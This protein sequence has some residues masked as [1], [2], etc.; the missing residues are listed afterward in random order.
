MIWG[1][2][3]KLWWWA[4]FCW[5]PH[6]LPWS[7]IL[8]A[9]FCALWIVGNYEKF[10]AATRW[11]NVASIRVHDADFGTC[12][13]MEAV[14]E[15]HRPFNGLRIVT[16]D[17]IHEGEQVE[18]KS[19]VTFVA[20]DPARPLPTNLNLR[21]WVGNNGE[22]CTL[23]PGRYR[24]STRYVILSDGGAMKMQDAPDAAFTVR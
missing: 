2:L 11:I 15:I 4:S 5:L 18:Q 23:P 17:P 9:S 8:L 6:R 12:P 24:V 10:F 21:W 14:R 16:V 22:V 13:R 20:F 3:Q 1:W 7:Q 19:Y